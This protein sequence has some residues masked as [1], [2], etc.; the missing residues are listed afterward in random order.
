MRAFVDDDSEDTY[1]RLVDRLLASPRFGERWGRHWMDIWRYS[2]WAGFGAEVRESQPHI[3]RWRDWI[4]T[5]LNRDK[6]Y[7]AMIREMLAGDEIAPDDPDTLRATGFLARNWYKFNRNTWLD[8]TV[9]HT[10]KAFLGITLNCARCHDHKYDP[11]TQADYYRLK[12]F[13]QSHDVATDRLPG[14]PDTT[15]DGVARVLDA[16]PTEL[17]YLFR[18]GE[19]SQPDKDH[20]LTPAVPA[21]FGGEAGIAVVSLPA[22]ARYPALRPHIRREAI[23]AAEAKVASASNALGGARLAEDQAREQLVRSITRLE[24]GNPDRAK[25]EVDVDVAGAKVL[26]C[27]RQ[28]SSAQAALLTV[29]AKI[30]ADQARYAD[31]PDS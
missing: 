12:A 5:S 9:E 28:L 18:R 13:F 2:D 29:R 25:I 17:T 6:P 22:T 4:V 24:G 23:D 14:Q 31:P 27:S 10:S 7:D 16:H 8:A 1:E 20:P 26:A 19:E 15:K 11:F 3:W 30:V 21:V